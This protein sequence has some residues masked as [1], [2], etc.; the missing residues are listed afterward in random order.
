MRDNSTMTNIEF[1]LNIVWKYIIGF[2]WYKN[3]LFRVLPHHDVYES[4][5]IF[6]KMMLIS[7]VFF[8]T[9][10]RRWKNGWTSMASFVLP[11]GIYTMMTYATTSALFIQIV[12]GVSV[13]ASLIYSVLLLAKKINYTGKKVRRRVY[14]NRISRCIYSISCIMAA[15][16]LIL[17][18]GIGWKGYFGT[19]LVSSSVEAEGTIHD[20]KNEDIIEANMDTVLKLRPMIWESLSTYDRIDVLQTVCNIEAHYLGLSDPITVQGDNLSTYTL[21]S[22]ADDLRLIRVNL[23]HIENDSAEEVLSTLLH[24]IYHSY[25]HRLADVY[26]NVL[27]EYRDLRLF[28]DA[29]YYS[30]EVDAYINPREDYYGYMSQHLE[31]DSEKYAEFGV[32]E[33]YTRI[34]TWIEENEPEI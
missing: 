24:E 33:Y 3:L 19:A 23:D 8:M 9:A 2:V 10:L 26:D 4:L 11:F 7:A 25:E 22:Y 5:Q 30:Y 16:M 18:V 20:T 21:G 32:Q 12:V 27:P 13:L 34:E 14:Q 1:L 29:F 15:A 6:F 28:Q 31:M 17:I